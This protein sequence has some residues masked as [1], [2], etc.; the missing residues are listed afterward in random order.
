MTQ[1]VGS[2]TPP[3]PASAPPEPS[4]RFERIKAKYRRDHQNPINNF[5]HVGVG[6]P[7]MAMAVILAPFR[8]LWA[9]GLFVVSYLIMWTGHFV[10]ERNLPTIFRNPSTPFIMAWAVIGQ[11]ASGLGRL[12]TGRRPV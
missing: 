2:P 7:I 12:V 10:F 6:W 1:A 9:L 11:I 4:S 8:P 5:L 3:A